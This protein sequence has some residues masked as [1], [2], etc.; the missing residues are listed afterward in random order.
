MAGRR[1]GGEGGQGTLVLHVRSGDIFDD[2]VLSYY[3]QVRGDV[4]LVVYRRRSYPNFCTF[5]CDGKHARVQRVCRAQ[6]WWQQQGC[7]GRVRKTDPGCVA[8]GTRLSFPGLFRLEGFNGQPPPE[9]WFDLPP[10]PR[11]V[12]SLQLSSHDDPG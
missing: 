12:S 7:C 11:L 5:P 4:V 8:A 9:R 1:G 2:A 3:G 6:R 10:P